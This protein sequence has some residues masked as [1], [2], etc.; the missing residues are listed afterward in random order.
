ML[1]LIVILI[2]YY[3]SMYYLKKYAGRHN[4]L[5]G[6]S[7]ALISYI[8]LFLFTIFIMTPFEKCRLNV[9]SCEGFII[10]SHFFN[11]IIIVSIALHISKKIRKIDIRSQKKIVRMNF[12]WTTIIIALLLLIWILFIYYETGIQSTWILVVLFL[13]V[14][15]G[16][17]LHKRSLA[18]IAKLE[19]TALENEPYVLFLRDF[20]I[21]KIVARPSN[22]RLNVLDSILGITI[23]NYLTEYLKEH[24]TLV[25]LGS[26]DDYLPTLGAKKIYLPDE[27]WQDYITKYLH[28]AALIIILEGSSEG[29]RWEL[30]YIKK[31]ILPE[32]IKIISLPKEFKK[33]S[34]FVDKYP[35]KNFKDILAE[36]GYTIDGEFRQGQLISLNN[37]WVADKYEDYEQLIRYLPSY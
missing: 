29:L 6:L 5:W 13:I 4:P 10:F 7:F 9:L 23:D 34:L 11:A 19:L 2:A 36:C 16:S 3:G 25:A 12:K 24:I 15:K 26:P 20:K 17:R 31:N 14:V 35:M 28:N 37:N 30:S 33:H 21:D 22:I 27:K 1:T 32:N 18:S 8:N